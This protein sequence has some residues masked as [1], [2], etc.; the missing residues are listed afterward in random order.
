MT[1]LVGYSSVE[2]VHYNR[3]EMQQK[4]TPHLTPSMIFQ[5]VCNIPVEMK[6]YEM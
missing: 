6:L 3:N 1:L 2:S 4:A 5:S